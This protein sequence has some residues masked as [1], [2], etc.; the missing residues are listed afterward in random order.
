MLPHGEVKLGLL[1]T[2]GQ[3]EVEVVSA[4]NIIGSAKDTLPG[5]YRQQLTYFVKLPKT[6]WNRSP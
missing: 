3:L 1:M 2:K 5:K 6:P 4:R